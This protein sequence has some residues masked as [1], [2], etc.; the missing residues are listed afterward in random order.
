MLLKVTSYGTKK[1]F[2][3]RLEWSCLLKQRAE[4]EKDWVLVAFDSSA[5]S[6]LLH[7]LIVQTFFQIPFCWKQFIMHFLYLQ[8]VVLTIQIPWPWFFFFFFLIPTT[9]IEAIPCEI[10]QN[11]T[12]WSAG[13]DMLIQWENVE[14]KTIISIQKP[15]LA[16]LL[17]DQWFYKSFWRKCH[18]NQVNLLSDIS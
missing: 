5:T 12:W 8:P 6:L 10:L 16:M 3:A 18:W 15:W 14:C 2:V 7:R 1:L 11:W 13:R 17:D 4:K 9:F